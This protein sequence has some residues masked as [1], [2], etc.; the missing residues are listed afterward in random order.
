MTARRLGLARKPLIAVPA[1]LVEQTAREARQA[2]PFGRFLVAG[3]GRRLRSR[4]LLAA[5]CATGDWDAVIVSHGTFGAL[6]VAPEAELAWLQ[7][8]APTTRGARSAAAGAAGTAGRCCSAGRRAR[9]PDRRG[10]AR[11]PARR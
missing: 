7:D 9:A 5:R 1:H 4:E 3:R 2:Y 8:A 11:G 6:P 10:C